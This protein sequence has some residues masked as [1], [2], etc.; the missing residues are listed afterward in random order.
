MKDLEDDLRKGL[1][2]YVNRTAEDLTEEEVRKRIDKR[3]KD[4]LGLAVN[5]AATPEEGVAT[6]DGDNGE[7]A[8]TPPPTAAPVE[9]TEEKAS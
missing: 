9:G 5:K 2:A 4:L 7:G 6:D 8:P 1:K 3:L